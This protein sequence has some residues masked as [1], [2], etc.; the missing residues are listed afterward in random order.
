MKGLIDVAR[1]G[2]LWFL[3]RTDG[4]INFVDGKPYVKQNVFRSL[5]PK[6]GRPDVDPARQARHG[7]GGA[8]SA[9]RIGA[10]RTGRRSR[11]APRPG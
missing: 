4:P 11:S 10:E 7:Q 8:S 9:P 5:D 2:Y 1:D 3:E 6:T